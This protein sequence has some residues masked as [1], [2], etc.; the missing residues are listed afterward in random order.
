MLTSVDDEKLTGRRWLL[1]NI[2]FV[3]SL[4]LCSSGNALADLQITKTVD[5]VSPSP[6]AENAVV[7][8][9]LSVT[10]TGPGNLTNVIIDD[11]P[12]NLNNLQF[13]VTSASPP[14]NS[15]GPGTNQY[16]FNNLAAGETVTLDLDAT[17]NAADACPIINNTA[18]V[19]EDSVTFTDSAA[20]ASIE[21]D[22][23]FTSGQFS[24]VISH[25]ATSYCEF[26]GDGTISVT[27]QNPTGASLTNVSLLENL[28]ASGLVYIA[29]TTTVNAIPAADPGIAGT[30]NELLTWNLPDLGAS[31]S[32]VITFDVRS[33][34][35]EALI[36]ANRNIIATVDFDMS[37]LAVTQ[38]INTGQFEVP[39]RQ[40]LPN[41]LKD[42]RNYDAGQG[43]YSDP[44]YGNLNDDVIWRVNVRNTGLANMQA[45]IMNDSIDGNFS[46]NYICPTEADAVAIAAANGVGGA[47]CIAMT[48]SLNV[49]NPFGNAADPDDI[50]AGTNNAFIYYVGRILS[51]HSNNTNTSDIS[52]GCAVDSPA[53]GLITVPASTGGFSPAVGIAETGVL[54]TTVVPANLQVT[55]TVTGSNPGQPLGTKGLVTVTIN[56]QTGGTIK[57]LVLR[58]VVP[59]GYVVD[60]TFGSDAAPADCDCT[61]TYTAAYGGTYDGFIDTVLRN[62]PERT[63]GNPLTDTSPRFVFTSSTTGADANQVDLLRNGDVVTL[64][65][66]IVMVEPARFDVAADLDVAPENTA[67]GTD[68]VSSV[69][70][71][72][73]VF[74]D[75]DAS[76]VAGVQGQTRNDTLGFNSNPEDLDVDISDALFILT[77]DPGTSLD[78]NVIVTNNGGHDADDYVVYVTLG[79]AMTAQLPYPNGCVATTNPPPHPHWNQPA[80][81]PGSAAVF[82]CY[83]GVIA[84]GAGAAE[85][86]TFSVIKDASAADDDLT[87][88]ADVVGE[89]TLFDATTLTFPAPP[90]LLNTTPGQQLA[91]NYTLDAV[92][93]R[94]LGFNLVKS[95]WYCAEDG[96]TEPAP[97]ADILSPAAAPPNLPT[98]T[99]NLNSQIGEDCAYR[100]EAGG[101]FGFDTPGFAL[102][103][104][105]NIAVTDDLP[106]LQP[107]L[108]NRGQGFI[109]FSGSSSYSYSSTSGINLVGTNGGAGTAAL[110]ATDI[111]WNFNAAGD[112]ITTKDKFFRVDLKT[113]LLNDAVDLDYAL[114][115]AGTNLHGNLSTNTARTSFEAVF[116]TETINVIDG[117]DGS[118]NTIPGYPDPSV[119]TVNLTEV[120]PNLIVTKQVCNEDLNT[121]GPGCGAF[122]DSINNGDTNDSYIYRITLE[123]ETSVPVRSPAFNVISTDTLD[124][125][126]LMLVVDFSND[127]LDNDGDTLVDEADEATLFASIPDNII[128]NGT[129]AVITVNELYNAQLAQVDPGTTITFYY[130]VNPD[131]TIAPLQTLTNTVVMTYDSLDGDFGNQNTPQLDNTATAPNDIGRARIYTS[132]AQTADVQMIPLLTQPKIVTDLSNTALN[133]NDMQHS[134]SVGEEVEY[135]L[136]AE[137]PVANLVNFKIRDELPPGI[138]CIEGQVIDLDAPPYDA[139]GFVPGGTF[140]SSCNLP[141]GDNFIEWNFGTQAVT[142]SNPGNRFN[143]VV[144]FITRVENIAGNV[145]GTVITNGG[146]T[147]DPVTCAGGVA[148]CYVNEAGTAIALD[149][150]SEDIIVREP[151]IALT[152]SFAPVV[153]SDAADILTVTV[154]ATNNGTAA[155]YNLQVL[156]NL[157]GSDLTYIPGS[158]GGANP[159]DNVDISIANR[160]VFSWDRVTN[161][162]YEITPSAVKTFTFQVRVDTTAQPLEI[163]DNTIQAKW[164]SL[165]GQNVALNS[166]GLIGLDGSAMGLR[167]GAVPNAGNALNDYETTA[168]ASTS[169]L[170]LTMSK[171]DLNP[172]TIPTIGAHR[173]F[174]VV[175]NLPEGTTENLIINDDLIFGG[176]SYALSRNA[177]FDVSYQFIDIISINGQ[178][179]AEAVFRGATAGPPTLPVDGDTGSITW[180]I[181]TVITDEEDDQVINNKNPRI[182]INY[183]ARPNN[184]AA[185]NDGVTLQNSATVTYNNGEDATLEALNDNTA[186]QTVVEPLLTISK[187]VSNISN[188]GVAPVAGDVLEYVITINNTGNATAF[189]SNIADTLDANL[190]FDAGFTPTVL[191]NGAVVPG[192]V[193]LPTGAPAGPLIWGRG[194]ADNSLDIPVAGTLVLTYRAVVQN[195]IQPNVVISNSALVDWTSLDDSDLSNAFERTGAGCPA[196]TAPNDYCSAPAVAS[197]TANDSN[198]IVKTVILDTYNESPLSTANDSIVRIGDIVTYQLDINIQQGTT[199]NV[200]ILDAVPAGLAFVDIVSINGDTT[201]DYD[202][203][204]SGVGSNFNYATIPAANVP[205]AGSTGPAFN[206]SLGNITNDAAGDPTTDT[207]VIVYRARVTENVLPHVASMTLTN[208]ANLSYIDGNGSPSSPPGD[209]AVV[210]VLQPI[211]DALSKTDRLGRPSGITVDVA[212]DVMAFRL[213]SCNTAGQARAYGLLVTDTLPTQINEASITGPTN[214]AL[215]PDVY[216]NN[217]LVSEGVAN[218]YVYTPPAVRGGNMV[219]RFNAPI[220]PGVCVDIDFNAGFY[221][222]FPANETWSNTVAVDEY[223]SLPPANAQLYSIVAPATFDMNNLGTVFPPP[224]K[225]MTTP[226]PALPEASIGDEVIYR[227]LVPQTPANA[228]MYDVNITDTLDARLVYV[229]ATDLS[230]SSFA[231]TDNTVLPGQVDLVIDQIPAGQQAI[232]EL[233]TRVDN[234]L[235]ANAGDSFLNTA[236]YRFANLP[237]NLPL[238]LGGTDTTASTLTI[239]E[240]VLAVAKAVANVTKPGQAP[241][242]GDILRYTVTLTASGG[243][244][245]GD[246]FADAFDV[247]M[248]DSLSLGLAYNGNET[249]NGGNTISTP[250]IIGDGIATPQT[251][252]WSLAQANADV[253]VAEGTA[254]TVTYDV[255]VLDS[256]LASQNLSNSVDIQ[257]SS[258][259][260]PDVNERD[261]S[262]VPALNDYFNPG[263]ATT[264]QTTPDN[265]VIT[266]SRLSD[267]YNPADNIVRIGDIVE[268]ELRINMQEGTSTNFVVQDNLP[269]GLAFEQTVSINGQT[270]APYPAV[271]PFSHTAIPAA[272]VAGN[273]VTGPTTVSW[274]A[275]DVINAGDNNI[276]NDDF[277]IVYRARVLNL[278]HAQ[279]NN[280][281]LSN[282]VNFDYGLAGG[283]APTKTSNQLIDLQ[284]PDL[285]ITKTSLPV[286]GSIIGAGDPVTYTVEITNNGTQPAYDTELQDTIPL[287]LRSPTITMVSMSLLSGTPLPG[288]LPPVYNPST[289]S[290]NWNFDTG[291]ADQ[292]N[293]PA[294]DTLRIVYQVQAD[295]GLGAGQTLTNSAQVQFYYSFDNNAVPTA[296]GITG[297]REI[298]GPSN[299][300]QVTLNTVQPNALL[301]TNPA[302]TSIS[303]G[304]TFSYRI[305][306]PDT[307]QATALYDVQILDNLTTSAADLMYA[308]A[309]RVSGSQPWTPVNIGTVTDNL[310][311]ADITN[312]IDIPAN[313]QVVIDITV[314][315]RDSSPP[316]VTGLAFTNA[317]SYTFNQVNGDNATASIGLGN[318]TPAMTIVEPELTLDKRGPAGPV[319]FLAPIPFTVVAEN[320]GTGPA[321]DTTIVDQL[322]AVPDNALL[323]GGTCDTTPI[324]FNARITTTADES[325]VVRALALG[326]DYTATHTAA[327]TC[328]LV[329]TTLSNNAR[330]EAGEKLIVSYETTLDVGTQSGAAL[331]N[332]AGVTRWF[333]LDTAGSGATGEIREYTRTITDGTPGTI[334]F[335]DAFTVIVEAPVLDVSKT[336]VNLSTGQNPGNDATPGDVLRYTVVV[337]NSGLVD[338]NAVTLSDAIPL[339]AT[340]V[341]DSVTLN[342]IPVGQ[343]DGGV[344]PLTAGIDIS[345]SDL[346]PPLPAT[347]GGTITVGQAATITFDV[348]LDPVITSGTVISNQAFA[349][350]PST[351][352]LPSD[353]PNIGGTADPTPTL[354]TS[355]PVFVVQKTSLDITGDPAVLLPGDTLRY[356]L[357][358]KNIGLEDGINSLLQDQ[359]PA[360]TS[361]VAN[362]T[363][364]NGV[365]VADP[366]AGISPLAAGM[367]INAPENTTAGYL[368]ADTNPA[369]N[370]VATVTF[371]VVISPSAVNGTLISNQGFFNGSGAGSGVFPQQP[372]DDPGTALV[373]D[374]TID[375]VGNVPVVDS[376][377]TVVIQND[378]NSNGIVDPGDTLR[379]TITTTNIGALPATNVVL[380]DAVPVNTTYVANSVTLNTLPA[381]Q[382]D[383]GVSPLIAGIA[384]SSSDLTPPLPSAGNGVLSP[385]NSATVTFDVIVNAGTAPGT[386]ISNQGFIASN[387]LPTEP[388]DADGNGANG[389]QPTV[390]VVGNVQQLA[391]TKQVFV[392]GGGAAEAGNQLE[393]VVRVTNIGGIT[394]TN[395]VITDDMA[396]PVAG[397]KTYVAGSGLLDGLPAGVSFAGSLLT[398]TVGNL[399]PAAVTELRFRVSLDASLNIGDRISNTADVT[400]DVPPNTI[401]ATTS[402]DIGGTPGSANLNGQV[403]HDADFSNDVGTGETLLADYRVELYRNNTQLATTVTDS[404][405][406]FFFSG[407]PPNL[408]TGDAYELRFL[409][410]GATATTASLGTTNSAFT[411]GA[412]RITDIFAASGTNVQNLNLPRQPNGVVYDSVLRVPVAGVRLSMIN[413]TRSNQPVPGSCF[414]DPVQ[415]SQITQANGY[416]KFDLNFS[417][418]ARCAPG[419]EY[420]IQ[421]LPPS[422]DFVGTTSVIIPPV[423]PVTGVAQ[424]VPSCPGTAADKIPAT[425]LHCENSDSFQPPPASIAPRTAGTDYYLKFQFNGAQFTNQIFNNHIPVDG[426]LDA[427]VAISKVAGKLNV[428]RADLVPYTITFNNTLGVPLFDVSIIDNFPAG[429]KY[430]TNSAR[431]DGVAIEP[432]INGR[433]LT[434]PNLRVDV[435]ES[436]VIKLLLIVGSGVG[437]GEY[438]NTARAIDSFTNQDVS[439]VASATVRVIP[440][441]TFDCSD[442]IGK[443]FEDKNLNS[444]QDEGERGIPGVQVAT[445]RGLRVT[446]DSHGRFHI[447]C[448]V[449]ANEV[450][451]SNFILKVDERSLPS[452][453]RLTTE[454][455]RVQRATRGKMLKFN[456][457]TAIHRV[458]RLDL[459]DGVFEKGK[460]TLRPQWR[461]RIELLIT[462]LQKEG[463]ILRLSYLA[464]NET[465]DEVDD[466]LDAIEELVSDRWEELDCCYKLVIEKEVFWRKGGPNA[467]RE[468]E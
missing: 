114:P 248:L 155:A 55:Q 441:P 218:D 145:E 228:V 416:Y 356:T 63:D 425:A 360:N 386:I 134:V 349:N 154:T 397:Q 12:V 192:F 254:V 131:I 292:Y 466:R 419:D 390:V 251:L 72:N 449:V 208:T 367:L 280:I 336:V 318:T 125:S 153:N 220:D 438:V 90:S 398:A 455:P 211:M 277:V 100:I 227:I 182:I 78:L 411:D 239:I 210:T 310:I 241:D 400:W 362:S 118:G 446:T 74:V 65:F 109:P 181:G 363:R 230:A 103:A 73:D 421:L 409:A 407:L 428:T 276:T 232:I 213:Q 433:Y 4:F 48:P 120:E 104:V 278:V 33:T 288:V 50:T 89:V 392:I 62:D 176:V 331:T 117:V 166:S 372:S 460:T 365:V 437:E 80:P 151:D 99:G 9:N 96:S 93:S 468:F 341:A 129:P 19:S 255:L 199:S 66:G 304:E 122:A 309:T 236:T 202:P 10:N 17:V 302:D 20:A 261:G 215:L 22:F 67:D 289:G 70:L 301:K 160:P 465:E 415:A 267:T 282:T 167:N 87:F 200:N 102:I 30:S 219:F 414:T 348:L 394:A 121:V 240:P 71:I 52:W 332:I 450:R 97:P 377:K 376:Q 110:D 34:N 387:E 444:Y 140:T 195:S 184:D 329:V 420:E 37:C 252:S 189:D 431:V 393:Y 324:N 186:A 61:V 268:Y 238:I 343:P 381:G 351:G 321:F 223:Y 457:G 417:D 265:N 77:N 135:T 212:N 169:V 29:G 234:N 283:A 149:F 323:T 57:N 286:A 178:P 161:P 340:Y 403:W 271:A 293:I 136:L 68:P 44:V 32:H 413:Q 179:P 423:E 18:S 128:G 266:K 379:Y 347:G 345:S 272:V 175:I 388:T 442:V 303:I 107:D 133:L 307:P 458:V 2:V 21:Y 263:S 467:G 185:T 354:I 180:D 56:N 191:I 312:G 101:W 245:P 224:E 253:D 42:G 187:A 396:L 123:N 233:R 124:A 315:L 183:Y 146:G 439:G 259:D 106:N 8:Y 28:Q 58:D 368:R 95:A 235:N 177:S 173:N 172:V 429:F 464:E 262:G 371:D 201:A 401:S 147:V 79:Q 231:I 40:P 35:A 194:N 98:L 23:G 284:Q 5:P 385:A 456:F 64:T 139:A 11:V 256:V 369:A 214:G 378:L 6:A 203:P 243:A 408:P 38:S 221:T 148:V 247:S 346:T 45:L 384:M 92:R 94:V 105:Q 389:N 380:T 86:I 150:S 137:L 326:T 461:S 436:R 382:P 338:A 311:I 204:A 162:D 406:V 404:N 402:I 337:G 229:S 330:I 308:S 83:R 157:V 285:S 298:Y 113:R 127:L 7:R 168:S 250:V 294:G 170:P 374:P 158:V 395:V 430:V 81:I 115:L 448:A 164:D 91:N 274:N 190:L 344:S 76:D 432:Q 60:G 287:G 434:W 427:V 197:I 391:I 412:Q 14:P 399:A 143:F 383:G 25:A 364:L 335:Q 207:F 108:L 325:T 316:N 435:N 319:N 165:P 225:T 350:S 257:W 75:F 51:A 291:V 152:K 443:V 13:T 188:A 463:S 141:G 84:P 353:D 41:V 116:D 452:G 119:R 82:A 370:N 445:A 54:S 453:Y 43:G 366:A 246:L 27:V 112:G 300:A 359:I 144:N 244:A 39:I 26:C 306:I 281:A 216:I 273:P 314:T 269:Q 24:N 410:P 46:I 305:T 440:D 375:V 198:S 85:T 69:A 3:G 242:A 171:T 258:R 111:T 447:T 15:S 47:P 249:V 138:R 142:Q 297:V 327:P 275:G 279:Q 333:S 156:D 299:I 130:R 296:G 352:A 357:T 59:A 313:E 317:A 209:S 459:A 264:L 206:W 163:L 226:A 270:V 295:A 373:D 49:A 322:P 339:N 217:V 174:E 342:G 361:Y 328:Q 193:A 88:R 1:V 355:A 31:A 205:A 196:I 422:A 260:G 126:D 405:G 320:I 454:N 334:D 159:P 237:G 290:A 462:E 222:D 451:G 424:N 53:G 426:I 358:V 16:S 132:I 36:T 418:A